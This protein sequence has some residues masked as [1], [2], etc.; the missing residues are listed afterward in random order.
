MKQSQIENVNF[1][2]SLILSNNNLKT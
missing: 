1:Y 2:E